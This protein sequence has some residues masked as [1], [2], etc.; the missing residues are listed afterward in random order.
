MLERSVLEKRLRE[1][2]QRA[3]SAANETSGDV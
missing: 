2:V 1:F 3:G